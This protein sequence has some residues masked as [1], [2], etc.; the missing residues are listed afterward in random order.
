MLSGTTAKT[1]QPREKGIH[2]NNKKVSCENSKSMMHEAQELSIL[3]LTSQR[4]SKVHGVDLSRSMAKSS[5][6]NVKQ[7]TNMCISQQSKSARMNTQTTAISSNSIAR[8]SNPEVKSFKNHVFAK[9][10]KSTSGFFNERSSAHQISLTPS[11]VAQKQ[12]Y[13]E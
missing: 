4:N 8:N 6:F 7:Q 5:A 1:P 12:I 3:G 10:K 9:K 13:R 11:Y 2:K